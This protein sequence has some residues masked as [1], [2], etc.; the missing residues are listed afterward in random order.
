MPFG[1]DDALLGG[2]LAGGGSLISGL[3]G[4]SKQGGIPKITNLSREDAFR[5]QNRYLD[6]FYGSNWRAGLA[7]DGTHQSVKNGDLTQARNFRYGGGTGQGGANARSLR[8]GTTPFGNL[9]ILQQL[10]GASGQG[11][12]ANAQTLNDYNRGQ[13]GAYREAQKFGTGMNAVIESDAKK[14]LADANARSLARLQGS[15]LGGS[16]LAVDALGA[17]AAGNV[18]EMARAK[19]NLANQATG[20]R[21]QQ[22]NQAT[23]GRAALQTQLNQSNNALRMVPIQAQLNTLGS[24]I[25]NPGSINYQQAPQQQNNLG[26]T[27]G[28]TLGQLGGLYL[29]NSLYNRRNNSQTA[30][31]IGNYIF[32][33]D[34][35]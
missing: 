12:N 1:I 18:R 30:A 25:V 14:S 32:G 4:G 17:N 28:D 16:T 26:Q 3:F 22:R 34:L 20:L 29:G 33:S 19:A 13:E 7:D 21:L 6:A 35:P 31:D 23:T 2:A 27:I 5:Q 24:P 9:P 15:G 8:G 10:Y 11:L